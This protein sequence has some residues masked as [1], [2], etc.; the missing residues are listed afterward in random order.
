[1]ALAVFEAIDDGGRLVSQ[2]RAFV[3]GELRRLGRTGLTDDALLVVSELAANAILHAGGIAA[4]AVVD[5]GEA[6][7]VEVHD[8]TRVSPVMPRQSA[9]AM[10]GRG[11][12]LVAAVSAGWGAEP[13][14]EGKVVWADLSEDHRASS[15]RAEELLE[16][17]NEE[18]LGDERP[19]VRHPVSLGDVPTS[20]LLSAKAHV[21]NLVRE[22]TL[23][24]RGAETN[25]SGQV[26]PHL[27]S[28]IQTVATRFSEAR[29][30]IKRQALA[31]ASEGRTR[32]RLELHLPASAADAG[33]AYLRALDEA[34]AYCHAARLLT[35]ETPPQ[36][37]LFRQWYVGQLVAQLRAAEAGLP[38][39]PPQPF[40]DRLLQEFD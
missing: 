21:D 23:A 2:V 17:W 6:V 20:L 33:E 35:V 4:V 31:A 3:A 19:V 15:F 37:R 16:F 1:M 9:E 39:P 10:T 34:D 25:V 7:R 22:F 27:A 36:H 40:E 5:H 18:W 14:D 32:V 11:L 38:P 13:T 26:P 24:A 8:R 30:S 29:Q 12:R 28:L